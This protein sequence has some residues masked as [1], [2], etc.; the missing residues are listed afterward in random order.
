MER[1]G[2]SECNRNKKFG[3]PGVLNYQIICIPQE[4]RELRVG[5]Q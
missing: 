4:S 3:L 5:G 2:D 1:Y